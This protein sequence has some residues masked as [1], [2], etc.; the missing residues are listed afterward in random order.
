[1]NTIV[2][3]SAG[4]VWRGSWLV[5]LAFLPIPGLFYAL[6]TAP[7]IAHADQAILIEEMWG[8]A[9]SSGAT[10]HNLTIL[11]G[12]LFAHALPFADLAYRCNLVSTVLASLAVVLFFD[13]AWRVTQSRA[14]AALSALFLMVSHSMWWHATVAEVYAANALLCAAILDAFVAY[15]QTRDARALDLAAALCGFAVFNHAQMGMWL[16]GLAAAVALGSKSDLPRR[17]ARAALF[18]ALGL[19][20]YALVFAHDAW[21]TGLGAATGEAAGGEF[22]HIFFSL[23]TQA[24][25]KT[26]RL[27]LMQWGWPSPYLLYASIGIASLAR[28]RDLPAT[29]VAAGIAF[30]VNTVFFAFYPTWDRYAFLLSSFVVLSFAGTVGLAVLWR[31]LAPRRTLAL[32][33]AGANVLACFYPLVFFRDLPV[34]GLH[35]RLW[36]DYVN[37]DRLRMTMTYG[38]YLANPNKSDYRI[39]GDFMDSAFATLPPRS[40][41]IDHLAA[42]L[43]QFRY[44][45]TFL[46][47]R[48]D[49]M[50]AGFVPKGMD[51]LRWPNGLEPTRA[52]DV[53]AE[54][55]DDRPVFTTSLV[56]AGFADVV[57]AA[58]DRQIT[59][60]P[61]ALATGDRIFQARHAADLDP[62]IWLERVSVGTHVGATGAT[63][64]CCNF[65][66]Q[67]AADLGLVL[68]VP[69]YNPPALC[70]VDWVRNGGGTL[71]GAP[72][73]VV[74]DSRPVLVTPPEALGPGAWTAEVKVFGRPLTRVPFTIE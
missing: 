22:R 54:H 73:R 63:G 23:S 25:S 44:A 53:I 68:Q 62:R 20:P 37:D 64:A 46:H 13:M 5:A 41:V 65:S 48:P 39:I 38:R 6:S 17:A 2:P 26:A 27:F 49:V 7:G 61:V 51:P 72:F 47:A 18:Y 3:E 16:P 40:L 1:M 35:S 12:R 71:N 60:V 59:F 11:V 57:S 15:D 30:V 70:Q 56:L 34:I 19:T 29:S 8:G 66:R 42:T 24:A 28:R 50:F 67:D 32:A 36:G 9:L 74:Y 14:L 33:F 55:L 69:R 43:F 58:L 10:S 21:T 4:G 45:Q 31:Q 52:L